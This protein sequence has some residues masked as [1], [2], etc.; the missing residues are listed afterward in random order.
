MKSELIKETM[1][2]SE[3]IEKE[4][5]KTKKRRNNDVHH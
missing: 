2:L 4:I 5:A 1:E 3:K